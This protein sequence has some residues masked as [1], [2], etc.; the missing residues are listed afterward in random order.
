MRYAD[1]ELTSVVKLACA[2]RELARNSI[3]GSDEDEHLAL[4]TR[5]CGHLVGSMLRALVDYE[6]R[7]RDFGADWRRWRA[8]SPDARVRRTDEAGD[9]AVQRRR[10]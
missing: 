1:S 3:A 5:R 4:L 7:V 9:G 2:A 8:R 6:E 10:R